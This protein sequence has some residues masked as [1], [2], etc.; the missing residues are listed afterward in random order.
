MRANTN[1]KPTMKDLSI[2]YGIGSTRIAS[3]EKC[4]W[5]MVQGFETFCEHDT[6]WVLT[7]CFSSAT[8]NCNYLS[9]DCKWKLKTANH[10]PK[11]TKTTIKGYCYMKL[12][13]DQ[14]NFELPRK[15]K[16]ASITKSHVFQ[17][18]R[19]N[20]LQSPNI[21]TNESSHGI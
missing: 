2:P 6:A 19:T 9:S 3:R 16:H 5:E 14:G 1:N 18:T 17:D 21:L 15:K 8:P 11:T 10:Q 4:F 13:I 7:G 12:T 20:K